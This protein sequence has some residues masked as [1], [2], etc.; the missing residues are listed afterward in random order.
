MVSG[1][2]SRA[3]RAVARD[4]E[5]TWWFTG[6]VAAL[7]LA[8]LIFMHLHHEMWRDEV[9][10]FSLARIA[11]SFGELVTGDRRYEGHPP[12][13]FWYLRVWSFLIPE[14]WGLH[15][16]TVVAALGAAVVLL[17]CAPFPRYLKVMLLLTY[18]FGFELTVMCRNYVLGWLLL[19]AF[20]ALY[21][22][23][24]PRP[25]VMAVV[26]SLLALT[27]VYGMVLAVGLVIFLV[28]E[29]IRLRRQ[30]PPLLVAGVLPRQL[31]ALAIVGAGLAFCAWSVEPMDPNPFSPGWN[32]S[33]FEAPAAFT[34]SLRR[35]VDGLAPLR[36]DRLDF[37]FR[38]FEVWQDWPGALPWGAS[39]L[40]V[41]AIAVLYRSWRLLL[42]FVASVAMMTVVQQARLVGCPRHW[43]HY[44]LALL[45]ACWL[46]R[47]VEPQRRHL[48]SL[49][50]LVVLCVAQIQGF[51]VAT[52]VDARAAFSG[53]KETA[54]FIRRAGM[55]DLPLVAGPGMALTV[56]V[57]LHRPFYNM[58]TE[59]VEETVSFNA[60]R[61]N[62]SLNQF[63]DKAIAVS[64]EHHGPV[65]VVL[66]LYT[67]LPPV[68][69]GV[70]ARLL[71][72]SRAP[73]VGDERF[74]VYRLEAH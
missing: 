72:T 15:V 21:H 61:R 2:L 32:F 59:E 6:V 26:L 70:E 46:L 50:L 3:W 27:S 62:F 23:L 55:Q 28:S 66:C 33:A 44:F 16:A 56:A 65:T 53:G 43:A 36:P 37:W 11:Q 73:V 4:R 5:T 30:T 14:V 19:C 68:P 74:V 38:W 57:Y 58:E 69:A 40:L 60:R 29:N 47:R 42:F 34:E 54:D 52:K 51:L 49:I 35:F 1:M 25:V 63:L 67:Q 9:H 48:P 31:V 45:A 10:A 8:F 12:L 39:A 71:F 18:D 13:W 41:A 64:R 24:R 17:R 22:P 20:C 7:Y